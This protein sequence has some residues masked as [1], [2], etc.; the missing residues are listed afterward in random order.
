MKSRQLIKVVA[1]AIT[2][3]EGDRL[4]SVTARGIALMKKGTQSLNF[5]HD[6]LIARDITHYTLNQRAENIWATSPI[7]LLNREPRRVLT[8]SF[9]LFPMDDLG[10]HAKDLTTA[11]L[12]RDMKPLQKLIWK[13]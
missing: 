5:I 8:F 11:E 4:D 9:V 1:T 7:M 6:F 2:G 12:E 13:D 3:V 10:F